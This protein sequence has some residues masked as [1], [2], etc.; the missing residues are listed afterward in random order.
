MDFDIY[1]HREVGM[2]VVVDDH[3]PDILVQHGEQGAQSTQ[4]CEIHYVVE[5]LREVQALRHKT[6]GSKVRLHDHGNV[7]LDRQS[8]RHF[9]LI[10]C[11]RSCNNS[12]F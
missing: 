2:I 4:T 6:V 11:S 5:I 3:V 7:P 10:R 9:L 12:G 8:W 1:L